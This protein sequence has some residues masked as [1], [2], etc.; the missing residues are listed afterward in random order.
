M[1]KLPRVILVGGAPLSGKTRLSRSIALRLEIAHIVTDDLSAAIRAITTAETHPA[2][3]YLDVDGCFRYYFPSYDP[4]RL[5]EDAVAFHRAAWPA[6]EAV[7]VAHADWDR[8]ALI[9]GWGILPEL[10]A[11]MGLEN[12]GALFLVPDE[13]VYEQRCRANA[14]FWQGAAN[15]EGL[16]QGFSRRSIAFSRYLEASAKE[17]RLPIVRPGPQATLEETVDRALDLLGASGTSR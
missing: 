13:A 3:H 14:S 17:Q 15:E 7:A 11:G 9:E 8:P 2:L 10:V 6:I 1:A 4:E 16:I 5:L 12:P